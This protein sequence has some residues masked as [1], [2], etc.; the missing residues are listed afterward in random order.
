MVSLI[1]AN[2]ASLP[3]W[4][5]ALDGNSS[6]STSFAETIQAYLKQFTEEDELPVLVADAA[7]YNEKTLL[8]LSETCR[9]VTRV[10]ATLK[11]VKDIYAQVDNDDLSVAD[12]ETRYMEFG[13]YYAGI[14][15]R[16]LLVL[17][18][19]SRIKQD[20]SPQKRV[21]KECQ[22]IERKLKALQN[23]DFGCEDA[24]H[25]VVD[26]LINFRGHHGGQHRLAGIGSHRIHR[27]LDTRSG[28]TFLHPP[29]L[30]GRPSKS[31]G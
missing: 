6:D 26:A 9:I 12:E 20:Q 15:Q 30:I 10:P 19:P 22:R 17:H 28:I 21:E 16:W 4:F 7:L 24:V 29:Q 11:A 1:C 5:R 23:K 3:T 14:K 27:Q 25:K 8:Q 2:Q 31:G 18:D 13:S